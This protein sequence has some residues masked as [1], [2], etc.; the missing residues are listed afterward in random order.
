MRVKVRE[1]SLHW[2][3]E[4]CKKIYNA[5]NGSGPRNNKISARKSRKGVGEGETNHR[6]SKSFYNSVSKTKEV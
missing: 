4:L 5:T 6:L 2:I 1:G 3:V